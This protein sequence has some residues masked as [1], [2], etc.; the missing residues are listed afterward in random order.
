LKNLLLRQTKGILKFM[1][2]LDLIAF[3]ITIIFGISEWV[4]IFAMKKEGISSAKKIGQ[5]FV[6]Y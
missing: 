5:Q 2:T 1:R 4:L 6:S 3:C